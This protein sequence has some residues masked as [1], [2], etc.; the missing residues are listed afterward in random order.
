MTALESRVAC[1]EPG[2]AVNFRDNDPLLL[3]L[4]DTKRTDQPI[5]LEMDESKRGYRHPIPGAEAAKLGT[6]LF[7]KP[8][9]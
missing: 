8:S 7:L 5:E 9:A 3:E 6:G 2:P 4:V 1:L